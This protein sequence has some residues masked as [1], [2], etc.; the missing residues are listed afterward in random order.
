MRPLTR[1][2]AIML[3]ATLAGACATISGTGGTIET[4][5]LPANA[6]FDSA[7][8][9]G[10]ANAVA[11]LLT[12]DAIISSEGI[13]DVAGRDVIRDV[14]S[15]LFETTTVAAFTLQPTELQVSGAIAFERGTFIFS[16]GPKDG[17]QSTR[18]GRY[19]LLRKRGSD[20]RWLVHRYMESCLPSP[21]A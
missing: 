7:Y 4:V 19:T 3:A 17:E 16:S 6:A 5:A 18:T 2:V 20:G 15:R 21:C 8:R 9:S 12:E 14:L 1:L 13:P 10:D 11:A